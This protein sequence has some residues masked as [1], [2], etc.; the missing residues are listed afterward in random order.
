MRRRKLTL[1]ETED[2][3]ITMLREKGGAQTFLRVQEYCG[4]YNDIRAIASL[5]NVAF[6]P[7]A[8]GR[9]VVHLVK[10][11]GCAPLRLGD[12]SAEEDDRLKRMY[13][14][15]NSWEHIAAVMRRTAGA[16]RTRA[17]KIGVTVL[18]RKQSN[19]W[20]HEE[21]EQLKIAY[22]AGKTSI[23]GRSGSACR[24]KASRIGIASITEDELTRRIEVI[25][26]R[27]LKDLLRSLDAT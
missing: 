9:T 11:T 23:P 15:G 24:N 7:L 19:D 5:G 14:A 1:Q 13:D 12:W 10:D 6:V 2:A 16:C 4:K 22:A 21:I 20:S 25:A 17:G 18:V 26:R 8:N 3:V 27:I